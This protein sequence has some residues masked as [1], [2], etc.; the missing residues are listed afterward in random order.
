MNAFTNSMAALASMLFSAPTSLLAQP[1][2]V[3][4]GHI[5]AAVVAVALDNGVGENLPLVSGSAPCSL[6]GAML[7]DGALVRGG[8]VTCRISRYPC[9]KMPHLAVSMLRR[10]PLRRCLAPAVSMQGLSYRASCD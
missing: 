6:A 3:F 1:R 9:N 8:G 5:I 4:G 2:N 10:A 7:E